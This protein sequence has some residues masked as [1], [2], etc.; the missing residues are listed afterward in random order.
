MNTL[1]KKM[2]VI[3]LPS[4][5]WIGITALGIGAQSLSNII[6]VVVIFIL[7]ILCAFIP[8]RFIKFKYLLIILVIITFLVRILTPVIPE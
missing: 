2:A 8:E 1:L 3:F 5:F 7:S 4:V 6:E